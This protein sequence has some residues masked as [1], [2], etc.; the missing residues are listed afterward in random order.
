MAKIRLYIL[1][2]ITAMALLFTACT[3]SGEQQTEPVPTASATETSVI[4]EAEPPIT[5]PAKTTATAVTTTPKTTAS[6]VTTTTAVTTTPVTTT[7][8]V[9]ETTTAIAVTTTPEA[10]TAPPTEV[11]TAAT[12]TPAETTRSGP[13][14]FTPK[15]DPAKILTVSYTPETVSLSKYYHDDSALF[16]NE[17]YVNSLI[18]QFNNMKFTKVSDSQLEKE[19]KAFKNWQ[20]KHLG[21]TAVA[22]SITFFDRS[23][24]PFLR[25]ESDLYAVIADG[26]EAEPFVRMVIGNDVYEY[27]TGKVDAKAI[28]NQGLNQILINNGLFSI[29]ICQTVALMYIDDTT[30]FVDEI[31][32]YKLYAPYETFIG[33]DGEAHS[34]DEF[35]DDVRLCDLTFT[36][37][38]GDYYVITMN[39]ATCEVYAKR[40]V[41][42]N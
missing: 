35:G 3:G 2:L 6:T 42:N 37:L 20:K 30:Y 13:E 24:Q 27:Y 41:K 23:G 1:A 33:I 8:P 18:E 32:E 14:T 29:E 9:T 17:E 19:K 5:E 36:Y 26:R 11:T 39:A 34:P 40:I 16:I 15:L 28:R 38:N 31:P 12:T 7:A 21:Y 4:T 25:I 10:V 22:E